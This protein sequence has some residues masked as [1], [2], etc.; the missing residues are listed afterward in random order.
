MKVS[1]IFVATVILMLVSSLAALAAPADLAIQLVR[2]E[3][4]RLPI[5][6]LT[7]TDPA[8]TVETAYRVQKEYVAMKLAGG[9]RVAGYKGGLTAGGVQ[10]RFGMNVP[11]TG[12]LLESG[13]LSGS[14]V[15]DRSRFGALMLETEIA[16]VL[17]EPVTEIL[18]DI[19]SLKRK[20]RTMAPA[21]EVPDLGFA[22]MK[23][24]KAPDLVAANVSARQYIIGREVEVSR[25]DINAIQVAL[26]HN[27]TRINLGQGDDALGDQWN[28]ALWLVNSMIDQGYKL[29]SGQI[30]LT[31]ALGAMLPGK[32]GSYTAD[33]GSFGR[34]D[35]EVR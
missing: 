25:F 16:L 29:E 17:N 4:E 3:Y 13:W 33:F 2:A 35:F 6:I 21:I 22:D 9:D 24:L 11:V 14:P 34:I 31:G 18:P 20:I 26:F 30:L 10:K 7:Q 32:P 5:P 28:A 8:M 15:L 27:G 12:I 19:A 23:K 1:R